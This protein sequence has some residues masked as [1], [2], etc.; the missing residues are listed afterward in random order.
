MSTIP[1]ALALAIVEDTRN[2]QAESRQRNPTCR[3]CTESMHRYRWVCLLGIFL[4][5]NAWQLEQNE[6]PNEI[7][8][9][10]PKSLIA[11]LAGISVQEWPNSE[12]WFVR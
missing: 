11:L 4:G 1:A 2:C 3:V 7:P 9:R 6:I 8:M 10:Y 5:V 12:R